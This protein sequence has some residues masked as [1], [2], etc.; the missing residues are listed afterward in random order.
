VLPEAVVEECQQV[1]EE[2]SQPLSPAIEGVKKQWDEQCVQ[3]DRDTSS[4]DFRNFYDLFLA[5]MV[6]C[7]SCEHALSAW[8]FFDV[9]KSGQLSWYE[10]LTANLSSRKTRRLAK[11]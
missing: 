7:Y 9:G 1:V 4:I 8:L 11:V 10:F 6:P 2:G 5:R 3:G